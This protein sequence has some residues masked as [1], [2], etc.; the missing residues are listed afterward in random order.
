VG[1]TGRLGVLPAGDDDRLSRQ[2]RTAS[3]SPGDR[4]SCSPAWPPVGDLALGDRVAGGGRLFLSA[5][6][7]QQPSWS[8]ASS[9]RPRC[10]MPPRR[11]SGLPRWGAGAQSRGPG[12]LGGPYQ[13][14]GSARPSAPGRR[15][16]LPGGCR[17]PGS[18]GP[19]GPAG[20]HG[21]F[22]PGCQ[23]RHARR[24]GR[25]PL[26]A[27]WRLAPPMPTGSKACPT[28]I[29]TCSAG[30]GWRSSVPGAPGAMGPLLEDAA[31][32]QRAGRGRTPEIV[33]RTGH[34]L[35]WGGRGRRPG[36][37]QG[38]P[39]AAAVGR[40]P[41]LIGKGHGARS[42]TPRHR[43]GG[44][45]WFP[46]LRRTR[47][48]RPAPP[49]GPAGSRAARVWRR[50]TAPVWP[51]AAR[52]SITARSSSTSSGSTRRPP[53]PGGRPAAAAGSAGRRDCH[54]PAAGRRAARATGQAELGGPVE[55][56]V[57]LLEATRGPRCRRRRPGPG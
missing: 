15:G 19:G 18:A 37:G 42:P 39:P 24:R 40:P 45:R 4:V 23:R 20:S 10:C 32:G 26:P 50:Q 47:A 2:G 33:E 36:P 31:A 48:W 27:S 13:P 35:F 16:L 7:D 3:S 55:A 51:A 6:G 1:L 46:E 49:R 43:P 29:S 5:G 30:S 14:C 11:V 44:R 8:G 38:A 28:F 53:A 56:V 25:G 41:P 9:S 22:P 57:G 54:H 12:V 21:L 52:V 34:P 17:R